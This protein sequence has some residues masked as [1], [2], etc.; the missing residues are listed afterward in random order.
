MMKIVVAPDSYK[1]S[2]TST[3]VSKIIR[4]AIIS[5][6][7]KA[8][9]IL[10]PMA[11][12]GEGTLEVIVGAEQG[13]LVPILCTGPLGDR[14]ETRYGSLKGK[15]AVIECA[16]IAGLPQVL[17]EKR[18][19]A[20]T[21]SYG[22]GEVIKEVLD[23]NY[24]EIII[25]LGGSAVNDAGLG[26]LLALGMKA[27]NKA[28]KIVGPYGHNLHEITTIDMTGLD[29]R[30]KNTTIKVASDVKNP[31][32][33]KQGATYVYG[34]QKGLASDQL[35]EYDSSIR[36]FA[37]LIEDNIGSSFMNLSGAGAAG[38]IGFA[39]LVLGAEVASGA[40]LIGK[41][42]AVEEAIAGADLVITGEG[43]SDEQTLFGKAPGYIGS[44]ANKHHV[45]VVL[46]SG[47]L[48]ENIDKLGGQFTACFSI[49]NKPLS[50][51]ESIEYANELLYEQTKQIMKLIVMLKASTC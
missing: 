9:V 5:V 15:T 4:S 31:L 36:K 33:G 43:K 49:T 28:G 13:K 17:T 39:L 7:P 35:E 14:I 20:N 41:T 45:P 6:T 37:S 23:K 48:A 1:G 19:P 34:P 22:L 10:K 47:G 46:L 25:G 38:G 42:I 26:M 16:S 24:T 2:L 30:I 40:E 27:Y 18:N 11:D 3:Q 50:L 12:G 51:K 8:N 32:C 29:S 44:L 21:T